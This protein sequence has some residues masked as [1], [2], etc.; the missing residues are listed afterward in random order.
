MSI[1]NINQKNSAGETPPNS[2][3]DEEYVMEMNC[4]GPP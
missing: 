4:T 3:P 1:K 2:N